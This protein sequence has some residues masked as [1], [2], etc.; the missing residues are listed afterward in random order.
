[1]SAGEGARSWALERGDNLAVMRTMPAASVNLAYLDPPFC[2]G[3]DF[4]AFDDRWEWTTIPCHYDRLALPERTRDTIG[5]FD[6]QLG[7]SPELAWLVHIAERLIATR[8]VLRNSGVLVLHID[9]RLEHCVRLLCDVALNGFTWQ[10]TVIWRYRRWPAPAKRFQ[11]M[12]DVLLVYAGEGSTF[13]ELHLD[14]VA[15][16]TRETFGTRKQKAIVKNGQRA[17]STIDE[18]TKGPPLA[19]VWEVPII[20]PSGNERKRGERYPTQKPE[21][22]LERVILSLSNPGDTVLDPYCG[23]GTSGAVCERLGR[24]WIGIDSGEV[25]ERVTT[26]RMELT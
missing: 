4:G 19:D 21:A 8:R 7:K 15:Q 5:F 24:R 22:L 1:M 3:K 13:N 2:T 18:E 12:H 25:A 10:N 9:P 14:G 17:T 20:A 16:S 11:R 23:S 26:E 6:K